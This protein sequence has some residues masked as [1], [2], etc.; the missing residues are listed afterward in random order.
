MS[1]DDMGT[2]EEALSAP[3]EVQ[4]LWRLMHNQAWKPR[5]SED[6]AEPMLARRDCVHFRRAQ[7]LI[8]DLLELGYRI[9]TVLPP[10]KEGGAGVDPG[11][12]M[13]ERP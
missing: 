10:L 4:A 11:A 5:H 6:Q 9:V 13:G 1:V 8:A 3:P 7:G 2:L 12:S